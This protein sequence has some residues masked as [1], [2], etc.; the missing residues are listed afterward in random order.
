MVARFLLLFL[1]THLL[2]IVGR[3]ELF[4]AFVCFWGR[5]RNPAHSLYFISSQKSYLALLCRTNLFL[6]H[7]ILASVLL[8][9]S[10]SDPV[11]PLF[12]FQWLS[13]ILGLKFKHGLQRLYDLALAC[14][15]RVSL[16]FDFEFLK[17]SLLPIL[18]SFHTYCSI[19]LKHSS[20]HCF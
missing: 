1:K 14:L 17:H 12:P 16:S 11:T 10:K 9:K 6:I 13:V 7:F 20:P 3:L 19:Y 2:I 5:R 8:L 18:M 4:T 15:L